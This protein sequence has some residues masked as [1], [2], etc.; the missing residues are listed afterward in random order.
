MSSYSMNFNGES[1][2]N[3]ENILNKFEIFNIIIGKIFGMSTNSIV[4]IINFVSS[5]DLMYLPSAD[6]LFLSSINNGGI[7]LTSIIIFLFIQVILP[8]KF[9]FLSTSKMFCHLFIIKILSFGHVFNE[10]FQAFIIFFITLIKRKK[11][12]N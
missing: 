11:I 8:H 9:D 12:Y 10:N 6:S 2:I 7:F 3:S 5:K 4:Y 1:I